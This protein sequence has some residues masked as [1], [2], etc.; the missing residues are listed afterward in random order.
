MAVLAAPWRGTCSRA[1]K[2]AGCRSHSMHG[3]NGRASANAAH[4]RKIW[5]EDAC[6]QEFFLSGIPRRP[7]SRTLRSTFVSNNPDG[8][9]RGRELHGGRS[10]PNPAPVGVEWQRSRSMAPRRIPTQERR[11]G[12]TARLA[13]LGC[14]GLGSGLSIARRGRSCLSRCRWGSHLLFRGRWTK[15][16]SL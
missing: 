14:R 8:L 9:P 2:G 5:G 3:L 7:I 6:H 11:D 10:R 16:V 12:V 1:V 13:G 4:A 15:V